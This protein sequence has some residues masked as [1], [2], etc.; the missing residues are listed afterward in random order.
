MNL[1]LRAVAVLSLATV[2]TFWPGHLHAQTPRPDSAAISEAG[3]RFSAAYIQRD[4]DGI[5]ALYTTDAV[6]FPE[7]SNA[8]SGHDA[9][10]KYWMGG[11]GNRV[12]RHQLT[13]TRVVVDGDHAYDYGTYEITGER[14]GKA[15]GPFRG[16]YLVV[17]RRE[18]GGWKMQLDMWNSG[19]ETK[20]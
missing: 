17:W 12:T 7:R 13:P 3:R 15:W 1:E 11:S 6:I 18:P 14:E 9:I 4:V 19:P 20:P 10:R 5:M 8:I 2:G 16:K